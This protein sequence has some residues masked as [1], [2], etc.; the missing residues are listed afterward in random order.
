VAARTKAKAE[1]AI[2]A[3]GI[4]A[5]AEAYDDMEACA[6][7]DAAVV[8]IV[9]PPHTHLPL[10]KAAVAAARCSVL[11]C[12]KP[13]ALSLEEADAMVAALPRDG[14]PSG[15]VGVVDHELRFLGAVRA[16]RAIVRSGVL[17]PLLRASAEVH[18]PDRLLADG[19]AGTVLA[20]HNWWSDAAMGGGT[21][22][23]IGSH[24]YDTLRYTTGAGAAPGSVAAR[25]TRARQARRDGT[26]G[27]LRAVTA[28][29]RADVF[30]LLAAGPGPAG[31][32]APEAVPATVV[33][34]M[35]SPGRATFRLELVC[36]RASLVYDGG[37]LLAM[38]HGGPAA[39][40]SPADGVVV[41]DTTYFGASA[42]ED[43]ASPGP[44]AA[45]PGGMSRN[46]FSAGT[47]QLAR[48]VRARLTGAD[49][50]TGEG[51][52]LHIGADE[53]GA[54]G[55]AAARD[56]LR[57]LLRSEAVV[58]ELG[59]LSRMGPGDLERLGA[60]IEDGREVQR[61]LDECRASSAAAGLR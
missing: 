31:G 2:E 39:P 18:R 24:M 53:G 61:F 49:V 8:S 46:E 19:G 6:A 48:A 1:S 4:G 43:S 22:G 52:G 13:M 20:S 5:T 60:R 10:L 51:P 37:R 58:S 55:A 11:L 50:P 35:T 17:G 40:R 44:A 14:A 27:S 54:D 9:T 16:M 23:A 56:G 47:V 33:V 29:D 30:L 45:G 25:L 34:S 12:E 57:A 21:L 3:A 15:M 36:D 26:S 7:S 42:G 59:D 41:F 28:D 38:P 32:A